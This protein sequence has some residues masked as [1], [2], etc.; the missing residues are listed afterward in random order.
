MGFLWRVTKFTARVALVAG[1]VKL[2]LD[3][4]VWSLNTVKGSDLYCRL[5]EYILPGTIVYPQ[6][7]PS[8]EEVLSEAGSSWN[9]GVDRVFNVIENVPS[10]TQQVANG[11]IGKS[12]IG[13]K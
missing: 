5:K 12:I 6:K 4:D 8:K 3:N 9:S 1:A 2:S 10:S 13:S 7:L 11:I